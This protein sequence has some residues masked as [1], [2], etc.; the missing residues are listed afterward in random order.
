MSTSGDLSNYRV[1][2]V[3]DE[4]TRRGGAERVFEEMVRLLPHARLHALYAGQPQMTINGYRHS[5]TTTFL[6]RFPVWFRRHPKRLLPLLPYA[7][8]QIDL[9]QYDIVVSSSSGLAKGIIT[10][11]NIPHVCYC[12][13]PTRYIWDARRS[14]LSR[15]SFWKKLPSMAV[16]H[17]LRLTDYTSAQ[18]VDYWLANS[19]WTQERIATY[20][21]R[22]SK[23]IYPPIDT[24]FFTPVSTRVKSVKSDRTG[25][26]DRYFLC[27]GRLSPAKSFEQAIAICEK[28]RL[29]LVI[30]GEGNHLAQLKKLAGPYTKFAGRVDRPT[31]RNY[32]RRTRALLQPAVE[33]FGMASA[34]ALACGTPVIAVGL[35]G[36][37]EIVRHNETGVLYQPGTVEALAE[38]VRQFLLLEHLFQPEVCQQAAL[39]FNQ[40][41]FAGEFMAKLA[42]IVDKHKTK[43]YSDKV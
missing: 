34:E 13:T 33:D 24:A 23:I 27:V 28:L 29:P 16:L 15:T 37:A 19:R 39:K 43:R 22:P 9:S 41:R 40:A 7:A 6:Q 8:E 21:R 12:H 5:I 10:R 38:A 36:V 30:V 35:G 26:D 2:L 1:A 18:R 42:E 20:Y 3:H 31:L 25:S 14:V 32:Y 11:A 4:L 17:W